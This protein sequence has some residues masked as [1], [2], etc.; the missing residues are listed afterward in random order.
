MNTLLFS[1]SLF[2][3]LPN[4]SQTSILV[5]SPVSGVIHEIFVPD[6]EKVEAGTQL[7]KIKITTASGKN[8]QSA[9]LGESDRPSDTHLHSTLP[10]VVLVCLHP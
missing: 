10:C 4:T 8:D 5:P 9:C 7:C 2:L 6:G 1:L 3:S